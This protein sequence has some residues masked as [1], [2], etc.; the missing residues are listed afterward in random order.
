MYYLGTSKKHDKDICI[1]ASAIATEPLLRC[2]Y[3]DEGDR[4]IFH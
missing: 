4:I 1:N 3:K 2:S